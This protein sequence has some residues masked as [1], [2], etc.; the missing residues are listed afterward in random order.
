MYDAALEACEAFHLS[1]D[2]CLELQWDA[3]AFGIATVWWL[4]WP[5]YCDC[6]VALGCAHQP[7]EYPKICGKR[8]GAVASA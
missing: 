3:V 4:L 5:M 1:T 6:V 8:V 7:A 2:A